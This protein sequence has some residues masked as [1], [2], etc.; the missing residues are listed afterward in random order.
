MKA[1]PFSPHDIFHDMIFVPRA[2]WAQHPSHHKV[3]GEV[4]VSNVHKVWISFTQSR[5]VALQQVSSSILIEENSSTHFYFM[6]LTSFMNIDLSLLIM[7]YGLVR[8]KHARN[9]GSTVQR[10]VLDN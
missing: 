2:K 7:S 6:N 8:L 5:R 9:S 10:V 3:I 4:V 1:G